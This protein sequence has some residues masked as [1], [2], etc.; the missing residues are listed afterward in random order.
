MVNRDT[1]LNAL[2]SVRDADSGENVV[3]QGMISG[4]VIRDGRVGF[5][6]EIDPGNRKGSEIL[7]LQCE[8]AVATLPGVDKVTAVLTAQG[9]GSASATPAQ[10]SRIRLASERSASPVGTP[11]RPTAHYNTA[12]IAGV[13]HV[14]AV[15]SGKGGVGKSTVAVNLALALK[16]AGKRTGLLDADIYGPSIPRMMRLSGKPEVSEGRLVPPES[17][18]IPC[19]SMGLIAGDDAPVIWRGPMITKAL[20]QMLRATAWAT[21]EAPLDVLLVDMPPGT[22]DIQLSMV[23]QVPLSG[24][25]IVTTPQDVAVLDAHKCLLAFQRL[26]VP[27][28]GV[29]E[30]MCGFRDPASGEIT[31][32]FGQGGGRNMADKEH[33]PFLG[34]IPLDPAIRERGDAG[35]PA[36]AP[37]FETAAERLLETL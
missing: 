29:L 5:A 35:T 21:Q 15:A 32:I 27:V 4:L 34:E 37:A 10:V 24:A 19:M 6:I 12:P 2:R 17:Q 1:I 16:N 26:N 36:A 31:Y 30:N 11:Q 20:S 3:D 14:I 13:R 8:Q 7:R 23:Q 22:G 28:V 18:G 9:E 25:L 33:V